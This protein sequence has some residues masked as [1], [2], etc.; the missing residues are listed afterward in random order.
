MF[1]SRSADGDVFLSCSILLLGAGPAH[2]R[3]QTSH[4]GLAEH[5]TLAALASRTHGEEESHRQEEWTERESWKRQLM[6]Q[7]AKE[8]TTLA[9]S[10]AAS[11]SSA[12][13]SSS[14]P[15]RAPSPNKIRPP[16]WRVKQAKVEEQEEQDAKQEKG[17]GGA[18]LPPPPTY[19]PAHPKEDFAHHLNKTQT[20]T[21][22]LP[23]RH[24]MMVLGR[25]VVVLRCCVYSCDCFQSHGLRER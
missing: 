16:Y 6:E 2:V 14:A 13:A 23:Q 8:P 10:G 22:F 17:K 3:F 19:D 12:P 24:I 20:P 11:S 9:S 15:P 7:E 18:S 1:E 21:S 25:P 4:G 5:C